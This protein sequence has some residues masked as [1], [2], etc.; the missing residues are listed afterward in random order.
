VI[1]E[2]IDEELLVANCKPVLAPNKRESD[3]QLQQKLAQV[4]Q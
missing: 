4:V 1:E 2:E 3:A